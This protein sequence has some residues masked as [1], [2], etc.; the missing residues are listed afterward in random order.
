MKVLLNTQG[1]VAMA[2]P[3]YSPQVLPGGSDQ[4]GVF[5]IK[6]GSLLTQFG[7]A[8]ISALFWE[9]DPASSGAGRTSLSKRH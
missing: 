9:F 8:L 2:P 3:W 4:S 1:E 6:S 7:S 5:S